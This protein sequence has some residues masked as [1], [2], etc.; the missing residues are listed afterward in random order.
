MAKQL[1]Q[2]WFCKCSTKI[3]WLEIMTKGIKD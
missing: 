3:K 1:L 2:A